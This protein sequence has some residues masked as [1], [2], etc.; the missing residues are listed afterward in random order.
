VAS[1]VNTRPEDERSTPEYARDDRAIQPHGMLVAAR[2]HDLV[3]THASQNCG[4]QLG[5]E[6]ADML[7]RTLDSVLGAAWVEQYRKALGGSAGEPSP[8]EVRIGERRF[9][10]MVHHAAA[11]VVVELEPSTEAPGERAALAVYRAIT[12]LTRAT[13]DSD[14][15][16]AAAVAL[17]ELT[18]FDRVMV[19]QLRPDGHGEIVA[20]DAAPGMEPV[21]GLRF[22]ESDF[23]ERIRDLYLRRRSRMI[24]SSTAVP[25]DIVGAT[26][27]G[28][29]P[30]DLELA[31][32][33]VVS[34]HDLYF[35]QTLG[36]ASL[37]SLSLVRGDELIGVI[38]L[39]SRTPRSVSLPI[40]HGL[41]ALANQVALQQGTMAEIARL[42]QSVRLRLVRAKLIEQLRLRRSTD[43]S[44]IAT[45]LLQGDLTLLDLIPA[46]GAMVCLGAHSSS[47]GTVPP[48]ASVRAAVVQL[49]ITDESRSV[50][51]ASLAAD[52]PD[53][54]A[55]LPSVSGLIVTP[56]PGFDGFLAWFRGGVTDSANWFGD[57]PSGSAPRSAPSTTSFPS[58]TSTTTD[59]SAAWAGLES[60]AD[61]LSR[62]LT[63]ALLRQAET[64]LAALAMRDA[65]TGL[66]NRRLLMDRLELRLAGR[67]PSTAATLL[68]VDLDGFKAVNDALGHDAGD[69]VLTRIATRILA[70]TRAQD[71]VAR[72]GGD[73]FVILLDE[74]T[75]LEAAAIA[76]RIIAAIRQ[77]IRTAGQSVTVTAS[78]GMA[79]SDSRMSPVDLLKRADEA[80]YRAKALGRD[81]VAV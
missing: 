3:I 9:D 66:P 32:L 37:L 58:W 8:A 44:A 18:G 23:P 5:I 76:D 12:R 45:A 21:R 30:L 49:A 74:T 43:V 1:T 79:V 57:Q 39:A 19:N 25:S 17:R 35:M 61:D 54:A 10:V 24:V 80:M 22:P 56:L 41:E 4:D 26:G 34:P 51:S 59:R 20:E 63:V 55:L 47:I 6:A 71:T 14:L 53:A 72:L 16:D 7:G 2:A 29:S 60:E 78:V 13:T 50:A 46:D 77:P 67:S 73:E 15:W 42:S 75:A 31:E 70:T 11:L 48:V 65:L 36:H 64:Q 28:R 62:D 81:Q 27:D 68:F 38:T 40:R 52:H 33:G 69:E